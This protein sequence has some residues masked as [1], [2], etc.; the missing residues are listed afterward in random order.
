MCLRIWNVSVLERLG[1]YY[2]SN[3]LV[4]S[5]RQYIGRFSIVRRSNCFPSLWYIQSSTSSATTYESCVHNDATTMDALALTSFA[6]HF[7]SLNRMDFFNLKFFISSKVR[8]CTKLPWKKKITTLVYYARK[9]SMAHLTKWASC[10][11]YKKFKSIFPRTYVLDEWRT[12]IQRLLFNLSYTANTRK[13]KG[14]TD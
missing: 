9:I 2:R 4:S 7:F 3:R 1:D 14:K 13:Q 12:I 10:F 5:R 8:I 6:K 11:I